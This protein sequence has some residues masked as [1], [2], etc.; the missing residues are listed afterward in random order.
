[1][2]TLTAVFGSDRVNRYGMVIPVGVLESSLNQ[3]WDKPLPASIGHDIHRASG[4]NEVIALHLQPNLARIFGTVTY[5]E[6]EQEMEIVRSVVNG[7]LNR[8]IEELDSDRVAELRERIGDK[9]TDDSRLHPQGCAAFLGDGLATRVFST[10]FEARDDAGLVPLSRLH[11]VAPGVFES[12]GLLYFAHPF[13]RRS[14]SRLNTL[15]DPF[16]LRLNGVAENPDLDVRIA[17]DEDLVGHP[18][19]LM[20]NIELQYWWGP[21][22]TDDLEEIQLGVSRHQGDA[23]EKFFNGVSATDFWWYEQGGL[24][25]FECEEIRDLDSPSLGKSSSQ[26]GC[27]FVHSILN[28]GDGIPNHLDGAIR[29]YDET[30]MLERVEVDIMGFGR[31]ADY[32]KLWRIDGPI[33]VQTWKALISDYYRDNRLAGEY[34]G[35]NEEDQITDPPHQIILDE[36]ASIY[37]FAPCTMNKGDGV[38][39]SISY[40]QKSDCEARFVIEPMKSYHS[41]EDWIEYV[42]PSTIEFIKLMKRGGNILDLPDGT[43][44]VA[45]EDMVS[46]LPLIVHCGSDSAADAN[47][48]LSAIRDYSIALRK[49]DLDRMLVFHLSVKFEDRDAQFSFA[50]HVNDVASWLETNESELPHCVSEIGEWA[51]SASSKIG[52]LFPDADDIPPLENMLKT[53]GLLIIERKFLEPSEFT[54]GESERHPA[55]IY[56]V[57]CPSIRK[58]DPLIREKRLTVTYAMILKGSECQKCKAEYRNCDCVKFVDD[59]VSCGVTSAE[60]MGVFWTDRSAWNNQLSSA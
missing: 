57:D 31:R 51:E 8:R 56:L 2:K 35:G 40:H 15:N 37:D 4:W 19:T 20:Q 27:R 17:L 39:I 36:N 33:P 3:A 29:L 32:T 10:I 9:L 44:I 38:R 46:C 45:F 13:F 16:L 21:K 52:E 25:T 5:A 1:M 28:P 47:V 11:C 24:K 23:S 42:E 60:L 50:G 14:L 49:R 59:G 12:E 26:F 41:G 53:S 22:F 18:A 30:Q 43:E 6:N 58:A 7:A 48:S 34:F 54:Q 55:P